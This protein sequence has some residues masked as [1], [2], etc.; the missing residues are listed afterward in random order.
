MSKIRIIFCR[1][2]FA[3][4]VNVMLKLTNSTAQKI[5][6]LTYLNGMMYENNKMKRKK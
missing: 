4:A 6:T 1:L 3:V 2:P 5:I